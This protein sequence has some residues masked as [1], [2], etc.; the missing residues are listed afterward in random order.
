KLKLVHYVQDYFQMYLL[1]PLP[2]VL[3]YQ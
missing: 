1:I 2:M 3:F